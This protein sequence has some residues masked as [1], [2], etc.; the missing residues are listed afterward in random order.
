MTVGWDEW[1]E[2]RCEFGHRY[3]PMFPAVVALISVLSS[4]FSSR[5][6][7]EYENDSKTLNVRLTIILEEAER[8]SAAANA[9]LLG[10]IAGKVGRP[11]LD[12]SCEGKG[13]EER[14]GEKGVVGVCGRLGRSGRLGFAGSAGSAAK[15]RVGADRGN[16]RACAPGPRKGPKREPKSSPSANKTEAGR[17]AGK[18]AMQRGRRGRNERLS[19]EER[20]ALAEREWRDQTRA[21]L[22]R[23]GI[24]GKTEPFSAWLPCLPLSPLV[25]RELS[26]QQGSA[27]SA[28]KARVGADRGNSRACAP[29]PRK[30]PKRE[31][32][33]SPSRAQLTG[34]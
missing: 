23:A 12:G 11:S 10:Q 7:W 2:I 29:G 27:G 6:T 24:A 4:F 28:A 33:S 1:I 34:P 14:R 16:S 17:R 19:S 8:N 3:E 13:K 5:K 21:S 30:G 18:N 22:I 26:S 32:K 20:D 31:P 9:G 15:A 25:P